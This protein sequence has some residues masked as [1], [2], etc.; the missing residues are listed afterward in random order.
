IDRVEFVGYGLDAPAVS[1]VD[2]RS[3]DVR[4]AAV[5]WLGA[6]GP[7]GADAPGNRRVLASRSRYAT[8]QL[9]A[10]AAIGPIMPPAAGRGGAPPSSVQ[11]P[12][13]GGGRGPQI[14]AADF[15][16]VQRLD[17]L[18]PP[19]VSA[20]DAFFELL[21]SHARTPYAELRRL[22]DAQE[23]LPEF[24]LEGVTLTFNV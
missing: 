6:A 12:T 16:T 3:V 7:K 9:R 21:F 20:K 19:M 17:T 18:I 15:T 14:P 8:D 4:G 2:Y 11:T 13:Q 24:R 1:H 23:P 22:A 10:S 5:V